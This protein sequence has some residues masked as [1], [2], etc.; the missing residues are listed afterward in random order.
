MGDGS[1]ILVLSSNW[2]PSRPI[3]NGDVDHTLRVPNLINRDTWQWARRKIEE[4]FAPRTRLDFLA[5]PFCHNRSRDSLDWEENNK[6]E[7]TMKSAYQ[8]AIRLCQQID[9]EH[10]CAQEDRKW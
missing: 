9:I 2:L 1:R 6:H 10:S 7:F 5:I 8:V 4:K 3:F